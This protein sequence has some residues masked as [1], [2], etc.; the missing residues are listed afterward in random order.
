[1]AP[2]GMKVL[3]FDA[4]RTRPT[5]QPHGTLC[6]YVGPALEHHRCYKVVDPSTGKVKSVSN[7]TW[8]PYSGTLPHDSPAEELCRTIQKLEVTLRE[9]TRISPQLFQSAQPLPSQRTPVLEALEALH[10]VFPRFRPTDP[11]ALPRVEPTAVSWSHPR[12]SE[13][14]SSPRVPELPVP[15]TSPVSPLSDPIA[16]PSV[17]SPI[18]TNQTLPTLTPAA[19]TLAVSTRSSSRPRN[20][21]YDHHA[22]SA[23]GPLTEATIALLNETLR[24][25]QQERSTSVANSVGQADAF[26]L[27]TNNRP[28]TYKSAIN[29]PDRAAWDSAQA[30]ELIR[31]I[32]TTKT[33]QWIPYDAKP[34]DASSVYYNPQVK[35]K[36]KDG[37]LIRRVR[38]TAGGNLSTYT[39]NR[40]ATTADLQTFKLLLN[41]VVTQNA[42]FATAD[43]HDFY[44]GSDLEVPEY[45]WLS[46]AQV[47]QSIRTRY[48]PAI[49][50]YNG[51]TLVRTGRLA[52]EK[53]LKLLARH[54]YHMAKRTE[55]LFRH[56]TRDITFT[57]V[58]DDFAI[59]YSDRADVEHLL[60]AITTEYSVD[61]DWTG[62]LYLG[63]SVT[64]DP[65]T[66]SVALSMPGYVD[67]AL[68]RF[69]VI[70]GTTPV[71]APLRYYPIN[72]GSNTS[73]LVTEDDTPALPPDKIKFIQEVIGV[74]L[75]YAR[76]VDA[77]MLAP[78][79]KL[80]S[81]QAKP[82]EALLR[83]IEHFLQYA[84][85]HPTASLVYRASAMRLVVSSDASYLSE[86]QSRSRA[87]GHHYLSMDGDPS[88]APLNGAIDAISVIIPAV[89][90]SAAEAE[91]AAL[92][93]NAQTAVATRNTLA[94]LGYPQH[95]TPLL[96]D[97]TTATGIANKTVHQKRSKAMDMRWY[98]LQDRIGLDE[99]TAT[100]GPGAGNTADYF[101]KAHPASYYI[102]HRRRYVTDIP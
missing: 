4:P 95:Q 32:D 44:L 79:N 35:V 2:P 34:K 101:T 67:S 88:L 19:P 91:L 63:M 9:A 99:F 28:L 50:W 11:V 84:S 1:M 72:Y 47:P 82:T 16:L 61:A 26:A 43:I 59:M 27:D 70:P 23:V 74:F 86:S 64:F 89:V 38:G 49:S 58:V 81:R 87:G 60:A 54:G 7:L 21:S 93:L 56:E 20:P 6:F 62:S 66:A 14:D 98:W 51:R 97:N 68:K 40:T 83:D 48:G 31:L 76:A 42:H 85:S 17:F 36:T 25:E 57:L 75:Y 96:S 102:E 100:W 8:H 24:Q 33:L 80:A 5:W 65:G 69:A 46:E 13:A 10:D 18:P 45:M 29:G 37:V 77:T 41:A 12:H 90:S 39:G 30:D 78:L 55:C 52:K 73:Q 71:H 3:A 22:Y 94:D 15:P 53:L 92:Y